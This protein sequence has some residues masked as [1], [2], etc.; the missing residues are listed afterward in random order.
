[1]NKIQQILTIGL[2]TQ[3]PTTS[4]AESLV[5]N[6]AISFATESVAAKAMTSPSAK[7]S[8][9]QALMSNH[10]NPMEQFFK[11]LEDTRVKQFKKMEESK[12]FQFIDSFDVM[13]RLKE[14][15]TF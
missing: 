11:H 12:L 6:S 7:E 8:L 9:T 2:Q 14:V 5:S 1:M 10:L 13:K 3:K 4:L 15:K